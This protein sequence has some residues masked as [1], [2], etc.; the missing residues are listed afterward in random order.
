MVERR[1]R[2]NKLECLHLATPVTRNFDTCLQLILLKLKSAGDV[3]RVK[4]LVANKDPACGSCQAIGKP[5]VSLIRGGRGILR[6]DGTPQANRGWSGRPPE[7]GKVKYCFARHASTVER[8]EFQLQS[9]IA[10]KI[11]QIRRTAR[12]E[13]SYNEMTS[14]CSRSYDV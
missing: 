14:C 13:H 9:G 8:M 5:F 12:L 10:E 2:G 7:S 3:A 6:H 1:R 4:T 11:L